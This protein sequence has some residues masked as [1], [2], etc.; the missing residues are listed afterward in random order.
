VTQRLEFQ[1]R[2]SAP[3]P[4]IV[5]FVKD[6]ANL[7]ADCTCPHR[8]R[9]YCKHRIAILSGDVAAIV[10]Y[11]ASDVAE[12]RTWFSGTE[13]AAALLEV[14]HAEHALAAAGAK[15]M[16]AREVLSRHCNARKTRRRE[17]RVN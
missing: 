12:V 3:D 5:V 4:Y 16:E 2:G 8:D 7:S 6:A 11:N 17:P 10:S 1:V 9:A 13:L 14:R 15:L